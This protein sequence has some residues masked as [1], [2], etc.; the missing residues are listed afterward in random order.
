M[1]RREL[2]RYLALGAGVQWL[3]G[4]SPEQIVALGRMIHQQARGR[5]Q[6]TGETPLALD[7][8]ANA[9]VTAAVERIVPRTDTPGATDAGVASFIDHMLANWYSAT[10]RDRVLEGLQEL[11]ARSRSLHG[12]DFVEGDEAQQVALL[13]AFDEEVTSLRERSQGDSDANEH[14][15]AMLK[16]LT[17]WGYCTSEVAMRETL[18]EYPLPFRYDGCAP[19]SEPASTSEAGSPGL[20]R[21]VPLRPRPHGHT[22]TLR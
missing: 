12:G 17:V 3:E 1:H 6:S 5:G 16:Y 9:T 20:T 8:H 10:D 11:D 2:L 13:T 15:F 22:S 18:G 19:L 14:W 4:R 21:L 7:A